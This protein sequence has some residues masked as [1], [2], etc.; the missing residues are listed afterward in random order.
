M[1]INIPPTLPIIFFYGV[2]LIWLVLVVYSA[3]SHHLF[4]NVPRLIISLTVCSILIFFFFPFLFSFNI[5]FFSF[6]LFLSL[7]EWK[8]KS[9]RMCCDF[10]L[11]PPDR[12]FPF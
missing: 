3:A 12:L 8:K 1:R 5:Y 10:F 2:A 6:I 11:A 4:F 9:V 7:A